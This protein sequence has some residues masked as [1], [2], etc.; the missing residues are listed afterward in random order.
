M[1]YGGGRLEGSWPFLQIEISK[2]ISIAYRISQD[3]F[4]GKQCNELRNSLEHIGLLKCV[5][6]SI[7]SNQL[8][9]RKLGL[10]AKGIWLRAW[11]TCT[12]RLP[13]IAD[14]FA[15][16]SFLPMCCWCSTFAVVSL[17]LFCFLNTA[18]VNNTLCLDTAEA[19]VLYF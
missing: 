8:T 15:R 10:I 12:V 19:C 4:L 3:R 11:S 6:T 14:T 17:R 13:E 18:T 5:E 9:S 1:Y 7:S 16:P 2:N